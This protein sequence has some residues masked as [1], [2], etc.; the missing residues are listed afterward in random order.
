MIIDRFRGELN[1]LGIAPSA[2]AVLKLL[3]AV[4]VAWAGGRI[5]RLQRLRIL[6]LARDH[7][8]IGDEANHVIQEWLA[9]PPA[10]DAIDRG[11]ALLRSL[12][13]AEDDDTVDVDELAM[14]VACSEWVAR[15]RST[16]PDA[17]WATS[18][19]EDAAIRGVAGALGVDLGRSWGA[20]WR[21]LEHGPVSQ[22][23]PLT[24][25]PVSGV[26]P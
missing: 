17:P 3:P 23:I 14:L 2:P 25:G 13:H 10:R 15:G 11:L 18:V 8:G 5:D 12:A 9:A 22:P 26:S 7:L 4:T 20:L 19:A 6:R 1:Q 21:E 16:Q 24:Q